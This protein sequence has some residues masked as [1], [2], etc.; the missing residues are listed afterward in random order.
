MQ[1]AASLLR[2]GQYP[3][4]IAAYQQ[5]L[6]TNPQNQKATLGLAAAYYGL[7]NYDETRRLL[8]QAAARFPNSAAAL[9][10]LAK[11]DIH[12]LRYDDALQELKRAVQRE[13]ASAAAYEQM[14]V[15]YQAKGD[16]E[17]ALQQFNAAIRLNPHSAAAH[18]FRG[19]LYA[20]RDDFAH[21]Y[22]DA[23][24]AH[25]LEPNSQTGILLAKAST[26]TGKCNEAV[27]LLKPLAEPASA[28]PANLYLLSLAYKC[29]GEAQMAQQAQDD[30][31]LRSTKAQE[32]K[33]QKMNGDHLA[34][35]AGELA[36][37]NDLTAALDLLDQA[38]AKDPENAPAHALLAKIDF[39]RGNATKAQE[40]IA[41]ALR[42]DP[43]NPDYLY[44]MGKV[45][46][47][48]D[49]DQALRAFQRT[50]LVNP[51]ESDAYYEISQIYLQKGDRRRAIE[52]L[53]KAVELAPDDG[54]YKKAL[55]EL[56][57]SRPR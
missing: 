38:L 47:K 46:E 24:Q 52:A 17:K 30:Y 22:E 42:A 11:L 49:P 10:E 50:V 12:L 20:D 41:T 51:K 37:K 32:A 55:A 31:E 6:K 39:S 40:E 45:L 53:K 2:S 36:R 16:D 4:A 19:N 35:Q 28:D 48:A 9:I 15:A 54:D 18:Y 57:V 13:P 34:T 8:R 7:Y 44:V 21:A 25:H 56:V 27:E 29:A 3:A 5:V 26:H 1:D 14:G 23:Q 33:T 43:Y